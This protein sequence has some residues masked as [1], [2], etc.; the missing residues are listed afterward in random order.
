[1][2]IARFSEM[3]V[4]ILLHS[5]LIILQR[6]KISTLHKK[7]GHDWPEKNLINARIFSS[8]LNSTK[9]HNVNLSEVIGYG[10]MSARPLALSSAITLKSNH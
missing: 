1:M 10:Y 9:P 4:E 3:N 8:T 6:K 2:T 7:L 5:R